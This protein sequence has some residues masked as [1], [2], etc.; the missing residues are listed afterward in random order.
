MSLGTICSFIR[1]AKKEK[2]VCTPSPPHRVVNPSVREA[3]GN[4]LDQYR[5]AA[6]Q[7]VSPADVSALGRLLCVHSKAG[8][9]GVCL[10]YVSREQKQGLVVEFHLACLRCEGGCRSGGA[11]PAKGFLYARIRASG[12]VPDQFFGG[13]GRHSISSNGPPSKPSRWARATST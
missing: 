3:I 12:S 10:R 9:G 1:T 11:A 5:T 2:V 13:S 4:V 7:A 6:R 8:R